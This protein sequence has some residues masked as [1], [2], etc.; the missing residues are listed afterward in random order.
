MSQMFNLVT[1]VCAW[2]FVYVFQFF[3]P[4]NKLKK[5]WDIPHFWKGLVQY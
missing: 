2:Q 4:E 3:Y 1:A 5:T